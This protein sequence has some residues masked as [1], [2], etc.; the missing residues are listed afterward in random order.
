MTSLLLSIVAL[1]CH[2]SDP[3]KDLRE[4]EQFGAETLRYAHAELVGTKRVRIF[5]RDAVELEEI[6]GTLPKSPP[7]RGDDLKHQ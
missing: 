3:Q 7:S 5:G 6:K 2:D 4:L 1:G